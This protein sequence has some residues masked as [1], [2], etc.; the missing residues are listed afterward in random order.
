MLRI[1][2][3]LV[4]VF[5]ALG[6]IDITQLLLLYAIFRLSK[7]Y[8]LIETAM[9]LI[10]TAWFFVKYFRTGK[11]L[12]YWISILL[13]LITIEFFF[14]RAHGIA[15]I[16]LGCLLFLTDVF[17]SKYDLISGIIKTLPFIALYY[18]LYIIDYRGGSESGYNGSTYFLSLFLKTIF[19][20]RNW[21]LLLNPIGSFAN[22]L[23]PSPM[24]ESFYK[25][26]GHSV[27][28]SIDSL[29]KFLGIFIFMILTTISI[30]AI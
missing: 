13:F 2:Q 24:I 1:L 11:I 26:I 23:I 16:I 30:M 7:S 19:E 8:Q 6:H 25:Y 21:S 29:S 22:L 10:L 5:G 17:K 28:S 14:L 20:N 15:L 12:W 27:F 18:F 3:P 9:F 4:E